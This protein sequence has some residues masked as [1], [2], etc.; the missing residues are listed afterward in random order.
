MYDSTIISLHSFHSTLCSVWNIN[1]WLCYG[2]NHLN[3]TYT[4]ILRSRFLGGVRPCKLVRSKGMSHVNSPLYKNVNNILYFLKK[5]PLHFNTS[6]LISSQGNR[7]WKLPNICDYQKSLYNM[8]VRTCREIFFFFGRRWNCHV[9][10]LNSHFRVIIK[11]SFLV[12]TINILHYNMM[13]S[14]KTTQN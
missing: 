5:R 14:D 3:R 10:L 2:W 4:S 7:I 12:L 13:I 6:I 8:I 9:F 1:P 11:K